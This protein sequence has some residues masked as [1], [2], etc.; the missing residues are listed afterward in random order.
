MKD[1]LGIEVV[2]ALWD[3]DRYDDDD[4]DDRDHGMG[5]GARE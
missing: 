2:D 4:D 5:Q 1:D 3:R